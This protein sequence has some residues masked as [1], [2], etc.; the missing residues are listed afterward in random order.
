[1]ACFPLFLEASQPLFQFAYAGAFLLQLGF[2]LLSSH[3]GA[4]GALTLEISLNF[5][6]LS[7]LTLQVSLNFHP[8]SPLKVSLRP[9]PRHVQ[10]VPARIHLLEQQQ[11]PR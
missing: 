10:D 3:F 5:H 4:L 7:P 6:P 1:M 8:L 9:Q 11:T 2:G